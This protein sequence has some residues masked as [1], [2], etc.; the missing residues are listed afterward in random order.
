MLMSFSIYIKNS[1]VLGFDLSKRTHK[2]VFNVI[3]EL[4]NKILLKIFIII[5]FALFNI[6]FYLI[7]LLQKIEPTKVCEQ[8]PKI[9]EINLFI[10]KNTFGW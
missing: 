2:K 8:V 10:D 4:D 6:N 7:I 3:E 9:V 1:A 5:V